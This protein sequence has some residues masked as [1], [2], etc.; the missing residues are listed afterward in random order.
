M[1]LVGLKRVTKDFETRSM[2]ELKKVGAYKYSLHPTTQPTCLGFKIA[3]HPT[4]Y[5]LPFELINSP[6]NNLPENFKSLWTRLIKENYDFSAHNSFF[7]RCIYDNI[8]VKRYG[9]PAISMRNRRCTAAKAS[10]CALPRNLEGAGESM[11]LRMQKDKRGYA[12]MMAT[13]KPTREWKAWKDAVD[14]KAQGKRIAEKK[15]KLIEKGEPE[16]FLEPPTEARIK[17][18]IFQNAVCSA[19]E[20]KAAE[21]FHTLYEYCKMD[22]KSEEELDLSLPDLIPA[23]QELWLLNQTLNWRG[24]E[25]DVPLIK[26]I[27]QMVD[28]ESRIKTQELDDL[29]LGLVTKPGSR[30][31]ILAFLESEGIILKDIK[32]K[33]VETKLEGFELTDTAR[34]LLELRKALSLTST[35]KYKS[36]LDRAD[37]TDHRVRD[38]L[39]YH[40]ASTGRDTGVGLQVHNLPR[41]LVKTPKGDPYFNVRAIQELD[42]DSLKLIYGDNLSM[43]FSSVIRNMIKATEGKEIHA[44]DF[45]KIEVGVLW[46]LA[47]NEAGLEIIRSGRDPYI[48]QAAKNLNKTYEEVD[49]AVKAEE[50][51]AVEARQLGKAQIL[52]CGFGL[53]GNKFRDLAKEQYRLTL[54]LKQS[55]EAVAS[56]RKAN[57]A[58][59]ELWAIYEEAFIEALKFKRVVHAGKC[60]FFVK[61]KFMWVELPSGRRLAYREPSIVW[62]VREYEE[63]KEEMINGVL[64]ETIIKKVSPPKEM[65]QFMAVNPKTKKWGPERTWG[66]T[67]A[68][69]ITQAVAR[70][71]MVASLLDLERAG[72]NIL[73]MVHD[74]VVAENELRKG[75]KA[76]FTDILCARPAWADASLPI[77]ASGWIGER[78]RKG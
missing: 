37:E 34:E 29:T 15:L 52:G 22:V 44:A 46:W 8:L 14:S 74:E 59:P 38:I 61:D 10:A 66:G 9:W 78:Y 69:N 16:V 56:Y 45:S 71:I 30:K 21:V 39:L 4:V 26:K 25:V 7:E 68:E 51:W 32:A 55:R 75:S 20:R 48:Y 2:A 73:F 3:G 49:A 31:S 5:F 11:H 24:V 64:V 19:Q 1:N 42:K 35:R 57:S 18:I 70:D 27:L 50:A 23:E 65:I 6:W 60:K 58:V 36:F 62:G 13:C 72:Y 76:Q 12:A 54:A 28:E 43:L 53:G 41:G 77:D 17:Q 33:T 67:L 63:I 47:N 40:G